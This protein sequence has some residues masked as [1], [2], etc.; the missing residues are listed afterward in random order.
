MQELIEPFLAA[1]GGG[2]LVS[3]VVRWMLIKQAKD[4]A[5][6][7]DDLGNDLKDLRKS[8]DELKDQQL[9]NLEKK[10]DDHLKLDNPQVTALSIKQLDG[11]VEKIGA[12]VDRVIEDKL[13]AITADIAKTAAKVE[14]NNT[15]TKNIDAMLQKHVTSP[16]HKG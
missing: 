11:L 8:Y 3:A 1:S 16:H 7:L 12:K 10:V 13:T 2:A 5:K 4:D 9:K 6:R 14:A 15:W